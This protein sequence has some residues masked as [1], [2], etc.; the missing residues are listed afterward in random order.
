MVEVMVDEGSGCTPRTGD[1]WSLALEDVTAE[2][3][4]SAAE[5]WL[6]PGRLVLSVLPPDESYRALR[7]STE[8][9]GP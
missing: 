9:V 2:D 7:G 6:G 8:A 3:V 1:A 4:Q 5:R